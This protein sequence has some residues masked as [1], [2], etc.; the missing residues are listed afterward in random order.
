MDHKH[1]LL[2]DRL[3]RHKSHGRPGQSFADRL[4]VDCV[5]LPA[6]DIRL[7]IHRVHHTNAVAQRAQ[8]S[9]PVMG[10]TARLHPDVAWW[11]LLEMSEEFT[12]GELLARHFPGLMIDCVN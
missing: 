5:I 12:S 1:R 6:F 7:Y 3:Q 11:K 10:R 9:G 2:L 8:L 4:S